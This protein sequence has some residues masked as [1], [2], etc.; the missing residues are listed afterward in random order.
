MEVKEVEHLKNKNT[1]RKLK[2]SP[3]NGG[4]Q[5]RKQL[6]DIMYGEEYIM[7]AIV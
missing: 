2:I 5:K 4:V 6:W 7:D 1:C 3:R